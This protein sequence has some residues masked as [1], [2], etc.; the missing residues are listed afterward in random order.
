MKK[1]ILVIDDELS[2]IKMVSRH[3]Q[4]LGYE[5]AALPS[6]NRVLE[7]IAECQPTAM[8]LDI[9]M[10]DKEGIEVVQEVRNV[11][12][13]LPIIAMSSNK[14]YLQFIECLGANSVLRKPINAENLQASL[15][16]IGIHP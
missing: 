9:V 8:L 2:T 6:A 14:N 7:A 10:P 12:P 3:L 16:A 13:A 15:S 11:Y 1:T 5:A 4:A